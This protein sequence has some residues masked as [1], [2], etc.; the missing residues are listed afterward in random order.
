M[1]HLSPALQTRKCKF[2]R[3]ATDAAAEEERKHE[4]FITGINDHRV[5]EKL[6]LMPVA[7]TFANAEQWPGQQ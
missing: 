3:A 5:S 7:A 1:T 6:L 4:T 2:K